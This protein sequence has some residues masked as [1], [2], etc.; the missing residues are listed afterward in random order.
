[1]NGSEQLEAARE[2][3]GEVPLI[4]AY[5]R[6]LQQ[7]ENGVLLSEQQ[8]FV[9]QRLLVDHA[10]DVGLGADLTPDQITDIGILLVHAPDIIDPVMRV[11]GRGGRLTS[12]CWRTSSRREPP[13]VAPLS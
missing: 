11:S 9:T 5:E 1:M 6:F 10:E 13:Q 7:Y 8:L 4:D 3:F 2:V 12:R